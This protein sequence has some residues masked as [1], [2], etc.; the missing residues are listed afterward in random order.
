MRDR[1]YLTPM[2]QTAVG[3]LVVIACFAWP[4]LIGVLTLIVFGRYLARARRGG[5]RGL[6]LAA[7][8]VMALTV[9]GMYA[10]P[11]LAFVGLVLATGT[12]FW[13]ATSRVGAPKKV[14]AQ[15]IVA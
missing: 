12:L 3:A 6:L 9:A 10:L 14:T 5:T 1:S 11:S 4:P 7:G 8:A 13:L 2:G 15:D